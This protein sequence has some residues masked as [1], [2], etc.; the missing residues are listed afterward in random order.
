MPLPLAITLSHLTALLGWR[1]RALTGAGAI[2]AGLVGTCI[3]TATGW[4]GFAALGTFFLGSSII[5][6]LA[7][8][9]GADRFDTKGN[10]RDAWQ[11][12]AN[13]GAAAV[14]A[15]LLG[16]DALGVVTVS[17]AAAAADTWATSFGGWSR[18]P[19]RHLLSWRV[20]PAGTSGGVT[21]LGTAG[22][23]LG[24]GLVA[25]ASAV[26]G[27]S[28]SLFSPALLLGMLGMLI[29]S[30]LGAAAQGRFHCAACDQPTE[31]RM[32]RCGR[33]TTH[34]GGLAWLTNDAVNALATGSATLLG[35][36]LLH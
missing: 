19:P 2:V 4:P 3:L 18:T 29:D 23:A 13:G 17:L 11:V 12:L 25:L 8:D 14:A 36:W 1:L 32:H 15:L 35:W 10:R 22:A 34:T 7:P 24:A 28:W 20:V 9:R 31:R 30:L 26:V 6:R 27:P 16:A 33:S 5:S 21:L